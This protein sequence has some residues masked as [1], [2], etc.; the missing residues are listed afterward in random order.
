MYVTKNKVDQNEWIKN[1]V[2]VNFDSKG[3]AFISSEFNDE[4]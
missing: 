1:D 4:C 3:R 2:S